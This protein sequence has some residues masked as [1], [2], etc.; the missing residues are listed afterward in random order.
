[1]VRQGCIILRKALVVQFRPTVFDVTILFCELSVFIYFSVEKKKNDA[2]PVS[3]PKDEGKKKSS[4]KP[5][6]SSSGGAK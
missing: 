4:S 2:R 3:T 6:S 5:P 1:M